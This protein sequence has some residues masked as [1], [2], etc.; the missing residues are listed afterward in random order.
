MTRPTVARLLLLAASLAI[1]LVAVEIAGWLL[2]DGT[3]DARMLFFSENPW[4]FDE[5]GFVKYKPRSEIR[6]AAL[7]GDTIEYDL[8]FR[9]NDEGFVDDTDYA[10]LALG[11]GR[12]NI[13]VVGDSF[14]AGYHGGV[15][16]VQTL[17]SAPGFDP[18]TH[19][20]FN[21]GVS[22]A[23]SATGTAS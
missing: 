7:Y 18:R 4:L 13:A 10:S 3:P 2:W 17:R 19:N 8:W 21:F 5:G 23:G 6:T 15:A 22:G 12:R 16:W 11:D 1:S 9:T 14:T 20:L